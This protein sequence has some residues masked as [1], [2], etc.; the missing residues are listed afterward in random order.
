MGMTHEQLDEQFINDGKFTREEISGL[1]KEF[2][3]TKI[4]L[5]FESSKAKNFLKRKMGMRYY[6]WVFFCHL[7]LTTPYLSAGFGK[8][9]YIEKCNKYTDWD[10]QRW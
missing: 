9:G 2:E 1:N 8:D 6:L 5:E 7:T 4:T 10:G 3:S